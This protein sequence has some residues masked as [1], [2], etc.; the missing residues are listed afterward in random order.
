MKKQIKSVVSMIKR[1]WFFVLLLGVAIAVAYFYFDFINRTVGFLQWSGLEDKTL[2]DL[3]ELV[4]IPLV[5]V[6]GGFLLNREQRKSENRI[7]EMRIAIERAIA[8]D[9]SQESNLQS[10][11]DRITDLLL[12]KKLLDANTTKSSDVRSIARTR[13]LSALRGLDGKRKGIVLLFLYESGL[14]GMSNP[15]VNLEN[16]DLTGAEL[17]NADLNGAHLGKTTLCKANL[18]LANLAQVYLRESD[19]SNVDLSFSILSSA[20]FSKARLIATD[21]RGADLTGADLRESNL[22][23]ANLRLAILNN[24]DLS[25]AYITQEQ[26]AK[27]ASA[28]NAILPNGIEFTKPTNG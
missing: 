2:W 15:I 23:D 16:A 3:L 1:R 4:I 9:R 7:A 25:G 17:A 6:V 24:A 5:L 28:D 18:S 22:Y 13:T 26:I 27:V 21:F 11:L 12:E 10:Y 8:N 20:N 14:I 19:L